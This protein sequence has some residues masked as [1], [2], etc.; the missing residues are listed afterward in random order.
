MSSDTDDR[1]DVDLLAS[2][3]C[4]AG[5]EAS[6]SGR[7]ERDFTVTRLTVDGFNGGLLLRWET[8]SAGWGELTI[9]CREG[10]VDMDTEAMGPDFVKS[11]LAKMVDDWFARDSGGEKER[12]P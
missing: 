8:K 3:E 6:L 4:V 10:K 1:P 9:S 2:D 11:V 7:D 5:I 12:A